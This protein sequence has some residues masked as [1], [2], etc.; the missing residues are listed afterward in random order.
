V[1][2]TGI[3]NYDI[4][5]VIASLGHYQV[6]VICDAGFPIPLA[7]KRIDLSLLPGLPSFM[8]V[9]KAVEAELCIEEIILAE[10]TNLHSPKRF[11]EIIDLFPA[12]NHKSIPHSEFKQLSKTAIA[13]IR[14]GE[15]TP[16]SN[17]M[18]VSGVTY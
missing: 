12:I 8:D 16:Y 10:E 1:K 5:S 13:C 3:L 18:L 14:S 11:Q 15:C 7:V 4:S 17:V 9:L 2:K 6:I